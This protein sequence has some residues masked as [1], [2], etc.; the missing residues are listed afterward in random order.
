MQSEWIFYHSQLVVVFA[1]VLCRIMSLIDLANKFSLDLSLSLTVLH[2]CVV[3]F[4]IYIIQESLANANVKRAT[5]VH[6]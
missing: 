2:V 1:L 3:Y 5:A 6:V 4:V